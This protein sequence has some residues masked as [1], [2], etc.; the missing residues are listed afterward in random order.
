MIAAAT[1]PTPPAA[2]NTRLVALVSVRVARTVPRAL[3]RVEVARDVVTIGSPL[4]CNTGA[5]SAKIRKD[6]SQR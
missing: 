6:R 4:A 1:A 5:V 3:G 2:H